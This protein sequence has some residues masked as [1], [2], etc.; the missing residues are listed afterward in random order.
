MT[1]E[2]ERLDAPELAAA[3]VS[4]LGL[5]A[6]AASG[7]IFATGE[8]TGTLVSLFKLLCDATAPGLTSVRLELRGTVVSLF[9]LCGRT[10][11]VLISAAGA[12]ASCFTQLMEPIALAS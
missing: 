12:A 4:L 2:A 9:R 6:G 5:C 7:L 10:A 8:L 1:A 11:P 3:L